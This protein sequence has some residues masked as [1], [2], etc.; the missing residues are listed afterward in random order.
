[1]NVRQ[2]V[3][4]KPEMALLLSTKFE[5]YGEIVT[6]CIKFYTVLWQ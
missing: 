2:S 4:H 5:P 1:M 6:F 3:N